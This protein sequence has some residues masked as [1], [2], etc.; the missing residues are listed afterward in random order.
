MFWGRNQAMLVAAIATQRFLVG[1]GMK[2]AHIQLFCFLN[3]R[4]VHFGGMGFRIV[5][6]P[7]CRR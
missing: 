3:F 1:A 6:S 2:H 7:G 5:E 4:Q